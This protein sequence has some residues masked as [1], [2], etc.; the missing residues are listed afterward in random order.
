LGGVLEVAKRAD[1]AT[2][3]YTYMGDAMGLENTT[4]H[5]TSF[6]LAK[7][8]SSTADW[9]FAFSEKSGVDTSN[10]FADYGLVG[11]K[12]GTSPT[13]NFDAYSN[14]NSTVQTLNK[15]RFLYMYSGPYN[16]RGEQSFYK[17]NLGVTE[18]GSVLSSIDDSNV[19]FSV[20]NQL[21]KSMFTLQSVSVNTSSGTVGPTCVATLGIGQSTNCNNVIVKVTDITQTVGSCSAGGATTTCVASS[22]GVTAQAV[23]SSGTQVTATTVPRREHFGLSRW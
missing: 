22:D 7:L 14:T 10:N 23:D 6:G 11:L 3:G 17:Q 13:F 9:Y 2:A 5:P 15:D 16:T 4:Y 12:L 1:A 8:N 18:R 20:A 21:A 19:V